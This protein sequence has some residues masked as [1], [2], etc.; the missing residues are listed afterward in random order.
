MHH[1]YY[2]EFMAG[3]KI[4]SIPDCYQEFALSIFFVLGMPLTPL[5]AEKC[6]KGS[7]TCES[8]AL[9]ACIYAVS[10][11]VGSI[12]KSFFALSMAASLIFSALFGA[13]TF[14]SA[15]LTSGGAIPIHI[16]DNCKWTSGAGIALLALSHAAE[17]WNRHVFYERK[18]W[19]F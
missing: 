10:V 7:I 19:E 13:V 3:L 8:L 5:L 11:G 4:P 2:P 1:A 14:A 17:R 6:F 18:F 16:H 12:N 9:T 15:Q